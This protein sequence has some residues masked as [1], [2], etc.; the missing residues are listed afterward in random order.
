MGDDNVNNVTIVSCD[1]DIQWHQCIGERAVRDQPTSA[2]EFDM[3][4]RQYDAI[5]SRDILRTGMHTQSG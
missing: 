3:S 4:S 5:S 2:R 1:G